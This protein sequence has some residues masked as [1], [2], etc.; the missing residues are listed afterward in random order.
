MHGSRGLARV[1]LIV[2]VLVAVAAAQ[3]N[4]KAQRTV[5]VGIALMT[6]QSARALS[7]T[8]E[9]NQLVQSLRR[10]RTNKKSTIAIEVVPLES[11]SREDAGKEAARKDC[12]YFVLTSVVDFG[13]PGGILVGPGGIQPAPVTLGNMD[14]TRNL[15]MNFTILEVGAFRGLAD[16]TTSLPERD[17][18]DLEAADEAMRTTALRI[19]AE[20]RKD[21]PPNID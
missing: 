3:A 14:P 16:G 18:N 8:W 13:R 11:S 7:P 1:S 15:T 6:N 17:G 5:K 20:I 9:R 10:L 21:R 4:G 2:L 19:A 12:H